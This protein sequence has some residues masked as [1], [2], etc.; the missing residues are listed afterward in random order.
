MTCGVMFDVLLA[1]IQN[2]TDDVHMFPI[3]GGQ[4][5]QLRQGHFLFDKFDRNLLNS[6]GVEGE[7]TEKVLNFQSRS[8]IF[9][10]ASFQ[11]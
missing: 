5:L 1:I 3:L 6:L 9:L 10:R 11:I 2:L 7:P 4:C 8:W